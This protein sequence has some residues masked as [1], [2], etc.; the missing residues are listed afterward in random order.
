MDFPHP[1]KS[2]NVTGQQT[3]LPENSFGQTNFGLNIYIYCLSQTVRARRLKFLENVHP[4]PHVTCHMSCVICHMSHVKCHMPRVTWH[5]YSQTVLEIGTLH[6]EKMFTPLCVTCHMSRFT[7]NII[8]TY[9]YIFCWKV[10]GAGRLRVCYQRCLPC[11]VYT[12]IY[13]YIFFFF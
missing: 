13:I 3:I 8:S 2:R 7:K 9:I 11:L 4:P 6:F 1:W 10:S 5:H 12:C